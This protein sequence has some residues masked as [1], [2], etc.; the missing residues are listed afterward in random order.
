MSVLLSSEQFIK[1][2]L[3]GRTIKFKT[4]VDD[5]NSEK[6]TITCT[7]VIFKEGNPVGL[8]DEWGREF[9]IVN[10]TID[11]KSVDLTTL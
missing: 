10:P 6:V 3:I 9:P 1:K 2:F 4:F 8:V 7:N 11:I 5:S